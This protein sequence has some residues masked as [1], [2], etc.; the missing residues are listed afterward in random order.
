MSRYGAGRAGNA[1]LKTYRHAVGRTV[2]VV[3][4]VAPETAASLEIRSDL[5]AE[6]E[7]QRSSST[8]R[9]AHPGHNVRKSVAL[10]SRDT[11][12]AF[13]SDEPSVN[14]EMEKAYFEVA[15]RRNA[16]PTRLPT[17]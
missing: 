12:S 7:A 17:L 10:L 1:F 13:A 11:V 2:P 16:R 5:A 14:E 8:E 15:S 9:S 6:Y 4:Q 3:A